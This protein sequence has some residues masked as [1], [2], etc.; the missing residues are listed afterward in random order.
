MVANGN[1]EC[2]TK[3]YEQ[4]LEKKQVKLHV[5]SN[6]IFETNYWFDLKV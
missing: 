2:K 5:N 6:N 1:E 4:K 3:S